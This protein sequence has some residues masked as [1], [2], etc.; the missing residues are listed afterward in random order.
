[1]KDVDLGRINLLIQGDAP[2]NRREQLFVRSFNGAI[3]GEDMADILLDIRRELGK[4][5]R[6]DY[7]Y[8]VTGFAKAEKLYKDA[9]RD[10]EEAMDQYNKRHTH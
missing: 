7:E 4:M 3:V 2:I 10:M 8:F 9:E 5:S 6:L 1:M